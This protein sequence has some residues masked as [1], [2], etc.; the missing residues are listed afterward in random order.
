MRASAA[1]NSCNNVGYEKIRHPII[2]A[3]DVQ[4]LKGSPL[5][6]TCGICSERFE[7]EQQL[8]NPFL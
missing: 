3:Y 6:I 5:D 7:Y 2:G 8:P 4:K 1:T